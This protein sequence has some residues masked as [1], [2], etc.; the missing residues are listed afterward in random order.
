MS[1]TASEETTSAE[2]AQ[3][4]ETDEGRVPARWS[5]RWPD[6]ID[7]DF[8]D[9]FDRRWPRAFTARWPELFE[10][11]AESMAIRIEEKEEDG[12][13]VIRAEIPDVDPENDIDVRVADGQLTITAERRRKEESDDEGRHRS[14]FRY[15]SYFRRIALPSGVTEDDVQASYRD[16]ILEVR[17]PLA[18]G[19]AG[20]RKVPITR[21]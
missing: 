9:L 17:V 4:V 2:A 21:R 12:S 1:E 13:L 8:G 11:G 19:D 20:A 7:R 14:E 16:G 10:G 3:D 18:E 5:R 15:G 6:W